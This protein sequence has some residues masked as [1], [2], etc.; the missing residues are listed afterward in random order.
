MAPRK[1]MY[2][3]KDEL[4]SLEGLRVNIKRSTYKLR[5]SIKEYILKYNSYM[6]RIYMNPVY[7]GYSNDF[8]I[9]P[10]TFSLKIKNGDWVVIK[11][12]KKAT[13]I[14]NRLKMS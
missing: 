2:L 14:L 1:K 8:S 13:N 9:S 5:L 3:N 11:P 6:D 10:K 7:K 12:S 4:K